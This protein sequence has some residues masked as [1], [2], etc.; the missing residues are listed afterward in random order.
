MKMRAVSLVTL[1][2]AM[3]CM[4]LATGRY[5]PYR[6]QSMGNVEE[7][8]VCLKVYKQCPTRM[9]TSHPLYDTVY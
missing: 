1:F 7:F 9:L 2:S 6:P 4:Q 8:I 3:L 5:T